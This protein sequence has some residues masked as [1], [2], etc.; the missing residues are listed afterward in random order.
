MNIFP[1]SFDP[2]HKTVFTML[3]L[4]FICC[5][6]CIIDG[7]DEYIEYHVNESIKFE[8]ASR[9]EHKSELVYCQFCPSTQ[10]R[11]DRFITIWN[12]GEIGQLMSEDEHIFRFCRQKNRLIIEKGKSRYRIVGIV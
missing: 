7:V 2:I 12:C 5:L 10:Y 3:S 6:P 9:F 4:I 11:H 1:K 8:S